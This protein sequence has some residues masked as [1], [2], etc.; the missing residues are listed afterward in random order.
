MEYAQTTHNSKL[1]WVS[2]NELAF[3]EDAAIHANVA[4][5]PV[6]QDVV[7]TQEQYELTHKILYGVMLVNRDEDYQHALESLNDC[8]KSIFST[9]SS[10]KCHTYRLMDLVVKS[11]SRLEKMHKIKFAALITVPADFSIQNESRS[12]L[13]GFLRPQSSNDPVTDI[14]LRQGLIVLTGMEDD[15]KDNWNGKGWKQ[16]INL[17]RLNDS[18]KHA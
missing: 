18:I 3:M 9:I 15:P 10:N 6:V 16:Y 12:V 7:H 8:S 5:A 1:I 11:D 17:S 13:T 14:Y 4:L 2:M